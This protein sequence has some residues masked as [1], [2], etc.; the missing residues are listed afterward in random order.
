[1]IPSIYIMA[2]FEFHKKVLLEYIKFLLVWY[3]A[4]F[5]M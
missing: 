3:F 1:M 5:K 4:C 2:F